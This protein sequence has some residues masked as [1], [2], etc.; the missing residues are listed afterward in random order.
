VK[1]EDGKT[2]KRLNGIYVVHEAKVTLEGGDVVNCRVLVAVEPGKTML[3]DL[4]YVSTLR[5]V[6][7]DGPG[8]WSGYTAV[9]D[10]PD[11]QNKGEG[12]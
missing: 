5:A 10:T 7:D 12:K 8:T 9:F 6:S 3:R 11:P 1:D 2:E 4:R